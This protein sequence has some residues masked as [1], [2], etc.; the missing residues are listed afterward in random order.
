MAYRMLYIKAQGGLWEPHIGFNQQDHDEGCTLSEVDEAHDNGYK[1]KVIR[2][3]R[4]PTANQIKM[5][6]EFLNSK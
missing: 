6:T 2:T 5:T 1:V 4:C 3:K